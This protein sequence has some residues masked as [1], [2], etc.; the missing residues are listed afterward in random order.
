M[1]A[2]FDLDGV[3]M[4]TESQYSIF[5]NRTGMEYLGIED[6][7]RIIKGQTLFQIFGKHFEGTEEQ[8]WPTKT[9]PRAF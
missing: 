6:F 4:D 7:G 5:W 9:R 8:I 3:I 1:I 2:L